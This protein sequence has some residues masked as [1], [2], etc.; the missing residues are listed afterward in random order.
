MARFY[1]KSEG[2]HLALS[3]ALK[4]HCGENRGMRYLVEPM[5]P[6]SIDQRAFYHGAVVAM[7]CFFQEHL[8]HKNS[9]DLEWAHEF[10]KT[11]FNGEMRIINGRKHF[12]GKSTKGRLNKG[13][14]DRV[15]D[16]L[17]EQY[18]ID[19]VLVLNSEDYKYWRDVIYAQGGPKYYIDYLVECGKLHV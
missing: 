17:E 1:A 18:A 8:D 12:A 14:I 7:F 10:L 9:K 19:R 11:H 3:K 4:T 5:L 16:Y 2:D 13:Y 15:I 6:E